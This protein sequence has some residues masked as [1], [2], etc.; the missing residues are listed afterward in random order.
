MARPINK[1]SAKGAEALKRPG[2]HS[3]GGGLYLKVL[4]DGRRQWVFMYRWQG[5]QREMGLGAFL[6][7]NTEKGA[8]Y[9]YVSLAD[10]RAKAGEARQA[11]ADGINPMSARKSAAEIPTFGDFADELIKEIAGGFRNEKHVEQWKMTLGDAYCKAI[12]KKKVNEITTQDVLGVLKPVWTTVPET[13]SRVRGR[14]ERVLDAAKAKGHRCGE[15][16]ALWRGHLSLLLPKRQKL[17]RGHHAALAYEELPAFMAKLDARP[18]IAARAMKFTILTAAR[19]GETFGA[20]WAE[21]DM[22][23]KVWTVPKERMKAGKEHRVPLTDPVIAIL[24]AMRE[25]FGS[26][27]DQVIFPGRSRKKPLSNTAMDMTLRRMNVDVTMHGFRSTFRDW[28]GE[29]SSFSREVAEAALAHSVGDETELAYR[30]GDALEKRR[31]LMT[32]WAKFA[33][34][35]A[36]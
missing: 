19:S 27:P 28:C 24:E 12:R 7:T 11:L 8:S 3:D 29:E 21:F 14:I 17:T 10:A 32:A 36:A 15:N 2:R 20:T 31:K 25:D 4:P 34:K 1:F 6:P 35:N 22:T 16:P 26:A 9:T 33:L 30:R 13:A 5:S 23:K 18:D